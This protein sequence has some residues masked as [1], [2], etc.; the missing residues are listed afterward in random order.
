L[1]H[2]IN[3]KFFSGEAILKNFVVPYAIY[4]LWAG[5]YYYINFVVQAKK[6]KEKEYLTLYSH[7]KSMKL[8]GKMMNKLGPKYAHFFFMFYHWSFFS[9]THILALFSF[10]SSY[11]HFLSTSVW[12]FICVWNGSSYYVRFFDYNRRL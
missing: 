6:F 1:K 7:F 8:P 9:V 10:Y 5:I 4:F 3:E 11:F 2:P 12:L